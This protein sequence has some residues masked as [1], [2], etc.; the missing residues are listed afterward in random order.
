MSQ[1]RSCLTEKIITNAKN[2]AFRLRVE[3]LLQKRKDFNIID[4]EHQRIR[5]K[6]MNIYIYIYIYLYV[7]I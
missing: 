7:Y 5:K 2:S 6:S 1:I 3:K 4:H